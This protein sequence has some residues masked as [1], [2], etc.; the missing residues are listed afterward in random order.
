ME[1]DN[2]KDTR[3][4]TSVVDGDVAARLRLLLVDCAGRPEVDEF[5]VVVAVDEHVEFF[6]VP[7]EYVLAV[8]VGDALDYLPGDAEQLLFVQVF[9]GYEQIMLI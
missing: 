9:A 8:Q 7:V 5:G 6:D 1:V 2:T 3:G 4:G